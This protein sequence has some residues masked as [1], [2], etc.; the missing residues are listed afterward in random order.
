[1]LKPL[2]LCLSVVAFCPAQQP[3]MYS[4]DR[5]RT[6]EVLVSAADTLLVA[7]DIN[8]DGRSEFVT[9]TLVGSGYSATSALLLHERAPGSLVWTST[10]VS[11]SQASGL[12]VARDV[13]FADL[14]GDGDLDMLVAAEAL[15]SSTSSRPSLETFRNDGASGFQFWSN[16]PV[17]SLFVDP[18]QVSTSDIDGDGDL[19]VL[20]GL[21]SSAAPLMLLFNDGSGRFPG[22]PLSLG[23]GM[24]GDTR[25]ACVDWDG[26]GRADALVAR[27]GAPTEL[28]RNVGGA[29]QL[30]AGAIP[31]A[32]RDWRAFEIG[33]L[34]WDGSVD[35]VGLDGNGRVAVLLNGTTP[36]TAVAIPGVWSGVAVVDHDGDGDLDI[37]LR[38]AVTVYV[39]DNL[40]GGTFGAAVPVSSALEGVFAAAELQGD[41]FGDLAVMSPRHGGILGLAGSGVG[42]TLDAAAERGPRLPLEQ[43]VNA[44]GP[45]AIADLDGDG[46]VDLVY[47]GDSL[48][49][50]PVVAH[51]G[52][53]SGRWRRV[54]IGGSSEA[55]TAQLM[56]AD[57]DLDGDL[58]LLR[59]SGSFNQTLELSIQ[60]RGAFGPL[61][62]L[63][64][65]T[66]AATLGDVNGD[67]I[68]DLITSDAASGPLLF[69]GNGVGGFGS[70][71][72]LPNPGNR[73]VN[74]LAPGDWD[75]DGDL[76]VLVF[77]NSASC[78]RLLEND[79]S[80][81]LSDGGCAHWLSGGVPTYVV[82]ADT[83][84]LDL[85]GDLD[86]IAISGSGVLVLLND[87]AGRF[88]DATASWMSAVGGFSVVSAH[89]L[90]VDNDVD[91]DLLVVTGIESRLMLNLGANF[92]EFT[93]AA[94]ENVPAN[95]WHARSG[96][97]DGDGDNDV[98]IGNTLYRNHLRHVSVPTAPCI[99]GA[100][101]VDVL[102]D[103]RFARGQNGCI[104]VWSA[105]QAPT[106]SVV[107]GI[108][109]TLGLSS[110]AGVDTL[111]FVSVSVPDGTGSLSVAIPA[112]A[113]LVGYELHIQGLALSSHWGL[114]FSN[115]VFER[116]LW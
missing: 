56:V 70:G 58:D 46:R 77:R 96:D 104:L 7:A 109:G 32:A 43:P 76:D 93:S 39:S 91:L 18:L 21:E 2:S 67:G 40:G 72:A 97:L 55:F 30:A 29:L 51:F 90:D 25:P 8:G 116:L 57:V 81:N 27:A 52:L 64:L 60:D 74:D 102:V 10:V 79:G 78:V 6:P 73:L 100:L 62:P 105:A 107:P 112:T 3:S 17:S 87:G 114:G 24:A 103:P 34:D 111:G 110:A 89:L 94:W 38:D 12:S 42:L 37:V 23:A 41:G 5:D 92:F 85:D 54:R 98:L 65:P 71:L 49:P 115:V 44:T 59:I 80:G 68:Q 53:G 14:D 35:A 28:W 26:D 4:P 82:H 45:A 11:F 95:V 83:G 13:E 61:T 101:V 22:G 33:D 9:R 20:M 108:L 19:D 63:G 50:D 69:L 84:D 36:A 15:P 66:R 99:G 16:T 106:P 113:S 88:T 31:A 75:G 1:M 86:V 48:D 47:A